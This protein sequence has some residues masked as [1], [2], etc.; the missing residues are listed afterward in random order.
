[1]ADLMRGT[2]CFTAFQDGLEEVDLVEVSAVLREKQLEALG[3][4]PLSLVERW[5]HELLSSFEILKSCVLQ[6]SMQHK[7]AA[8][9]NGHIAAR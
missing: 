3:G 7:Q 2:Q 4:S 1:M 5:A 8:D 9:R 6:R